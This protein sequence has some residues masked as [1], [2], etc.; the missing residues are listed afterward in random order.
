MATGQDTP[1]ISTT[2]Q[3]TRAPAISSSA[4]PSPVA[5]SRTTGARSGAFAMARHAATARSPAP[6]EAGDSDRWLRSREKAAARLAGSRSSA[7]QPA[8]CGSAG[9]QPQAADLTPL[10]SSVN[11][12]S[13]PVLSATAGAGRAPPRLRDGPG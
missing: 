6:D 4:Q 13:G 7:G 8:C 2:L 1:L 5:R 3:A 11:P 12:A 10:A 9:A